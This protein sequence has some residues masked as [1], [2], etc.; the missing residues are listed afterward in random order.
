MKPNDFDNAVKGLG[1]PENLI[2]AARLNLINGISMSTVLSKTQ[3]GRESMLRTRKRIM[4]E[5]L[6]VRALARMVKA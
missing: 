2:D 6:R 3:I 5:D 1:L 4:D